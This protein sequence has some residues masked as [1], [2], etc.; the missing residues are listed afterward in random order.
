MKLSCLP[1]SF[2]PEI[3]CGHMSIADW[4]RMG[5]ELGLEA[6]DLSILFLPERTVRCATDIRRQ[7]E[8]AGMRVAMLTSYP[9]FTHP[10][11]SVRDRELHL[12]VEAAA[13]AQEIGADLLR[14]TAGQAH[15][16]TGRRDGI[17]WAVEGLTRLV[18]QS[19]GLRVRPVYETHAKP[20]AWDYTDFSQPPDI[21]LEIVRQT[22]DANLG[23]N[24]DTGNATAF[25]EDPLGLLEQVI[26][27]VVSLH[28]ADTAVR[29]ELK[30]VLLGTGL[31]PLD[32]VFHRLQRAGWDGWVCMEEASFRGRQG[33]ED[34]A[35]YVRETWAHSATPVAPG[36]AAR[37]ETR[38]LA[39]HPRPESGKGSGGI[40]T[41]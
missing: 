6:I 28:V 34:S 5:A 35:R 36:L 14:V 33:V 25:C 31:A 8:D 10:Q 13:I 38:G 19:D 39:D 1:V 4:A 20:G 26:G 30:P 11:A 41:D 12:A 15:P 18:E 24:F 27:R 17:R 9:D 21:F 37:R 7:V 2:F 29:G 22:A 40:R 23:V 32:R 3:I 16:E